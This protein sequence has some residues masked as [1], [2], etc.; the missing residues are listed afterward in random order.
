MSDLSVPGVD[1][2]ARSRLKLR[3]L[4]VLLAIDRTRHIGRAARE[5]NISQPAISK[6]LQELERAAGAPLFERRANGSFPTPAGEALVRYSK[7]AFG[8]LD[9]AGS[10]LQLLSGG[11]SGMLAI[12][13]SQSCSADVLPRTVSLLKRENPRLT[14]KVSYESLE[15]LLRDLRSRELDVVMA[16][17][18]HGATPPDLQEHARFELRIVVV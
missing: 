8:A 3:H 1:W 5:L 14:I 17:K 9:R 4:S 13:C 10:E 12:G 11:S 15:V 18:W 16:R 7:E 6:T 2:F